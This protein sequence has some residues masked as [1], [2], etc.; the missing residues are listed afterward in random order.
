MRTDNLCYGR[1]LIAC[2]RLNVHHPTTRLDARN[3]STC[4][5]ALDRRY[6]QR[7]TGIMRSFRFCSVL[8]CQV[9]IVR[10]ACEICVIINPQA[11]HR[12]PLGMRTPAVPGPIADY[13]FL[14]KRVL[15][16]SWIAARKRPCRHVHPQPAPF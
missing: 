11:R 2:F 5:R 13:S 16:A 12:R 1:T 3:Y 10:G 7:R 6:D 4:F 14:T 9:L 15:I 8:K